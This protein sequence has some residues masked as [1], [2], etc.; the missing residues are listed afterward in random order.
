MNGP[1]I[2]FEITYYIQFTSDSFVV[3]FNKL[4]EI[5]MN[6]VSSKG[7]LRLS[8]LSFFKV[9]KTYFYILRKCLLLWLKDKNK[10]Y[11]KNI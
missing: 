9:R 6:L 11:A 7:N 10:Y 5:K 1:T 2:S 3:L 4:I 8:E